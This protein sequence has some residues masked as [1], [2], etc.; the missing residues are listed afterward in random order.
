MFRFMLQ[1][2]A[3]PL[4]HLLGPVSAFSMPLHLMGTRIC[5]GFPSPADDFIDDEIDLTRIL[6]ANRPATFLWRVSGNSMIEAGIHDGDV[7]VVDRS[8]NPRHGEVVVASIRGEVSLKLYLNDG[9][10]RLAFA[11]KDMPAFAV[12]EEDD[13]TVWGVVT[14]TL[15]KPN[16][17]CAAKS[18]RWW[19]A[20]ASIAAVSASFSP[21]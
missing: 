1:S 18:S 5:A 17:R 8:M 21:S 2:R 7:V 20:T 14:W 19:T 16:K 4:L 13:V 3:V 15:H 6:V 9:K 11:N 10:P 12:S